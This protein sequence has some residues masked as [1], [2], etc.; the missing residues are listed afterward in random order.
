MKS[1][2]DEDIGVFVE[3]EE[4]NRK[5]EERIE[6]EKINEVIEEE[7]MGRIEIN[8]LIGGNKERKLEIGDDGGIEMKLK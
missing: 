1:K 3:M 7:I 4:I 5:R 8:N 6:R 2:V